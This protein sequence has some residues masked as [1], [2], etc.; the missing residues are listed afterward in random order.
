M[1]VNELSKQQLTKLKESYLSDLVNEGTFAEVLGV[2]HDEPSYTD[3]A[4]VND[5]VSDEFL[6]SYYEGVE[7]TEDDFYL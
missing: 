7:F 1:K 2:D 4:N 6:M 5:L 3:L